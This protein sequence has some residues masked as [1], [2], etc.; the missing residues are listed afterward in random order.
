MRSWLVAAGAFAVVDTAARMVAGVPRIA[1]RSGRSSEGFLIDSK[2]I[3]TVGIV[4]RDR[5]PRLVACLE[6]YLGNCQRH[7]RSPEFVV[8]DD[9]SSAEAAD[10]TRAALQRLADRFDAR[11]RYAG[12]EEKSRFA[13]ALAAESGVSREII[14]FALFGDE[15][16]ALSTG[17]NR[18]SLLLDAAGA[19]MLAVD[20]DTL[21]RIAAAPECEA[22]RSFFSGYDPSEFWFFPDRGR[23]TQ[24]VSF[25]DADVLECHEA[26]LGSAVTG[27]G[28]PTETSGSVAVTLNGLVG[29]SGMASPRYYLSLT[30]ASRD[31]LVA[32]PQAYRSALESRE[33]LRS[34][35]QPT[36]TPGPFCMT[37]F[38]GLD[39]R[40]LL[41]PFFPVQRN[42]DGIFGLMLQKCVD[43]SHVAFLPWVLLH[44]PEPPRAFAPEEMWADA[45]AV[46]MADIVIAGVLD[47]QTR[48]GHVTTTARLADLGKHLRWLGS[49]SYPDFEAHVRTVQQFRNFAFITALHGQLHAFGAPPGFWADDVRRMIELTSQASTSEDHLVPRDLRHGRDAG[50]ARQLGQELVGKFGELLEAWPAMVGAAKRLRVKGWRLSQA[51]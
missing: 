16:C 28:G 38:L 18:N 30:G 21:C 8:A 39:N 29:D 4:T 23:A 32:S 1:R 41:P 36:I 24:S 50:A 40:L 49:L 12:P 5:L 44:A 34:V 11:V 27:L 42:S 26:L 17:A 31:R 15:R 20:D 19:L 13:A 9:S 33:I 3:T 7:A 43:G 22:A 2:T 14:G 35:R 10:R 47:H 51:P 48:T 6:S 46:R 37:T 45:A 25:V